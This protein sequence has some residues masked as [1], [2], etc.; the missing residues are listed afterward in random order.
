LQRAGSGRRPGCKP[1]RLSVSARRYRVYRAKPGRRRR[2]RIDWDRFG[3][4]AL[5]LVLF[6]V[7]V[8]YLNP[9]VNLVDAW[10]DSHSERDRFAELARENTELSERKAA[11]GDPEAIER[12]ARELGMVAPGERAYVIRDSN[13]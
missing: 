6:A 3:R 2:S 5:V 4:I 7:L 8:S 11:L 12:E 10:R 1:E 13:D 9:V